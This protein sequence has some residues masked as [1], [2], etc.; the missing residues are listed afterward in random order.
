MLTVTDCTRQI[1]QESPFVQETL[2]VGWLNLSQYAISILPEIETKLYKKVQLGS[3]I[4][5]LGR[6]RLELEKLFEIKLKINDISMKVPITEFN[7]VR[8]TGSQLSIAKLF[9]DLKS[10]PN[11]FLNVINGNTETGIFINSNHSQ[12]VLDNFENPNLVLS[13]LAA[14][15]IKFDFEY[16]DNLGSVYEVLRLLVWSKINLLEIISTYTELT[17]IVHKKDSTKVFEILNKTAR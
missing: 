1:V 3:I 17:L 13:D 16:L 7:F 6:I 10:V 2:R 14:I 5:A 15:S 11:N 8:Q 4:T 9:E 12:F